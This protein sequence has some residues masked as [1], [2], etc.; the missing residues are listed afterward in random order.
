MV[1]K[2]IYIAPQQERALKKLARVTGKKEAQI[3]RDALEEHARLIKEKDNRMAAW[4][5]IEATIE[6]RAKLARTTAGGRTWKREDLY[7]RYERNS[8]HKR[9]RVSI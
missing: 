2:Q 1:R 9:S 4:R 5:E 7:D 6:A 8:G 3:I